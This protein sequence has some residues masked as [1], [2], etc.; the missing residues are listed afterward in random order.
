[1]KHLFLGALVLLAFG[2]ADER[3]DSPQGEVFAWELLSG[4]WEHINGD[5]RTYEEWSLVG[6]AHLD[7]RG[8]VLYEQSVAADTVYIEQLEILPED[9]AIYYVVKLSGSQTEDAVRFELTRMDSTRL[10]FENPTEDF[11][12]KISYHLLSKDAMEV[13]LSGRENG[14]SSIRRLSFVRQ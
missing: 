10:V 7:G 5:D 14:E 3:M 9:G 8:Y 4:K 1:M 2:C 11:P 6:D 13:H 12:K